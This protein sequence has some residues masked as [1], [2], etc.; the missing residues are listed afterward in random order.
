MI[1]DDGVSTALCLRAFAGVVNDEGVKQRQVRQQGVGEAIFRQAYAFARQP[2]ERAMLA[3]MHDGVGA[4]LV[5][6]PAIQRIVMMGR[7]QVG[8]MIDRI[9]I[10][11][12]AARWLQRHEGIAQ[13][14]TGQREMIVMH[15]GNTRRRP[16]LRRHLLLHLQGQ[17]DE[18]RRILRRRH[19]SGRAR[20]LL[21]GE[22]GVVVSA[23]VYQ[24]MN[25]RRAAL[26]QIIN[27]ITRSLHGMQNVH[28]R[29]RCIQA[30]GIADLRRFAIGIGE[31]KGHALVCVRYAL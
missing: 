21:G 9:R 29:S 18:P 17:I 20:H 12:V 14:D 2:F 16:P 1:D 24:F 31:H 25:Q 19:A 7:R 27:A 6:Q 10:H 28:E 23:T 22:V 4:P 30:D 26:R 15:I 13:L 8:L 11:A 5:T 3:D